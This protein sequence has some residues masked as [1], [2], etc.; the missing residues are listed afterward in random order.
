[1]TS[2][3]PKRGRP[4]FR[5]ALDSWPKRTIFGNLSSFIHTTCPRHLNHSFNIALESGIEPHFSYSLL[6]EIRS[7]SRV[8]RTVL[9]HFLWKTSRKSSSAFWSAHASEP[10]L[11]TVITIASN[12]LIL[13]GR[14]IFLFFQFFLSLKKHPEPWLFYFC[15]FTA[16]MG[17]KSMGTDLAK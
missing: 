7:V 5:L 12:Y 3:H 10:Y 4:A 17:N 11:T 15:I 16:P 14:L 9:K 13:V 6:F 2:S 1:M 8:L